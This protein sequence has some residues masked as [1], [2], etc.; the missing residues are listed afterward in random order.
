[1][2]ITKCEEQC[3]GKASGGTRCKFSITKQI[4]MM[5]SDPQYSLTNLY[6]IPIFNTHIPD[7]VNITD[8][9]FTPFDASNE[10]VQ[11]GT[12]ATSA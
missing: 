9:P 3:S 4:N 5:C 7:F 8:I 11:S 12:P 2:L 6:F 1:M 10:I